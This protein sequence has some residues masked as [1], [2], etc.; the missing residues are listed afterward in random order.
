MVVAVA[1]GAGV[2]V[3]AAAAVDATD[4]APVEVIAELDV[5]ELS[6]AVVV[7]GTTAAS[8]AGGANSLEC[9]RLL[10]IIGEAGVVDDGVGAVAAELVD[11][12]VAASTTGVTTGVASAS[13]DPPAA[14]VDAAAAAAVAA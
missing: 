8:V 4:A 13:L 1:V 9:R 2:V 6:G 11:V 7:V 14:G 10:T 3:S 12:V 5:W